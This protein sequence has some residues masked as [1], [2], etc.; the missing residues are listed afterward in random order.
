VAN[1]LK[2]CVR[3]G[4]L[5][6][7]LQTTGTRGILVNRSAIETMICT[8]MYLK[9]RELNIKMRISVLNFHQ[10]LCLIFRFLGEVVFEVSGDK[11][12]TVP[13]EELIKKHIVTVMTAEI[14]LNLL[15]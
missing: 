1:H 8:I 10:Q 3:L 11:N 4:Q 5:G 7:E 2:R 9:V 13:K 15:K 12:S 14:L 6:F